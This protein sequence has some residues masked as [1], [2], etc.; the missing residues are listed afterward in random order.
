MTK[1]Q[2]IMLIILSVYLIVNFVV[3]IVYSKIKDKESSMSFT[4]KYFIGSR[5]MNGFVLAMTTVAT[6][7]SVSSFVSG[8]GAAAITYGFSQAWVAGVQVG[9][10]F[11]VLGVLGKKFA[12]VSRKT[13]AVTVAGYLKARY[14]SDALVIVTTLLMIVFFVTQMIGQFMGGAT[15]IE[16]VTGLPYWVA[17]AIFAFVVILY[18]AFGGFTAV[19]I[20]DTIQGIIM[21][22]GTFLLIL[23]VLKG[24][25]SF[26]VMST[27]LDAN[28]PGWDRLTGTGYTPGSL[29]SFW[30]LVGVGVLGLPQT[31]VRGMGF[32]DTKS[33]HKA[34]LIGTVVAGVL[35]IG[36]HV[37]GAWAGA[38]VGNQEFAS[39]DYVI[40]TLIQ[41]IMPVGMAGLFLAAPMAAVMSTVSSLLILASASLV[42]D[43]WKN[44]VVKEDAKRVEKYNKN[45]SKTSFLVTLAIGI[46]V[47]LLALTPPDII[48]WINLFAMGGLECAFLWPI[49]GGVFYKK[50]NKQAALASSVVGV[51]VYIVSYQFKLTIFNVNSVVWGLLIGGIV[52]FIVGAVTCKNGLDEDVLEKCF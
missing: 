45:L 34:M 49:V 51:L 47:L 42:K 10:A 8:P 17:L 5:G 2:I 37:A 31:A 40:P 16:T 11:L 7:A 4:K 48:F 43:L 28:L 15:L 46:I 33:C 20:T 38:L 41:E 39:S 26:E 22:I 18:T 13:G 27:N 35:M 23:Y 36:M 3:G 32:K 19:V 6:Y 52:Y 1:N 9:A 25:G 44:Y 21:L 24:V 12:L 14:K 29:L 50:G 30:V